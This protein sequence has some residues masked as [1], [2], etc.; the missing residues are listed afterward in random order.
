LYTYFDITLSN[1]TKLLQLIA[2]TLEK[3]ED[4]LMFLR[5][6]LMD[7]VLFKDSI[8]EK[9][10]RLRSQSYPINRTATIKFHK[11]YFQRS[12]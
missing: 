9:P 12:K 5:N 2:T 3:N 7:K 8:P 1:T 10:S 6:N 11:N 4:I